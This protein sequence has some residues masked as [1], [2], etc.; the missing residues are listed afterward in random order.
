MP[1]FRR[2][3]LL[4]ALLAPLSGCALGLAAGAGYIL[5]DEIDEADGK[6]DILEDLRGV[7]NGRN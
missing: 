4:L 7:G 2:A 1:A 5:A 6:L 3:A